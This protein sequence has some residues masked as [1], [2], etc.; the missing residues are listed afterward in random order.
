MNGLYREHDFELGSVFGFWEEI[1]LVN[2]YPL[3]DSKRWQVPCSVSVWWGSL[4]WWTFL[5]PISLVGLLQVVIFCIPLVFSIWVVSL[6]N[7]SEC[8]LVLS[9]TSLKKIRYHIKSKMPIQNIPKTPWPQNITAIRAKWSSSLKL[10][11]CQPEFK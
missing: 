4:E 2:S 3:V 7:P 8:V 10:Y 9:P 5:S 6:S 1:V 11:L